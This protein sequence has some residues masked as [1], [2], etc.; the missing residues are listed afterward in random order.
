MNEFGRLFKINIFGESHGKAIGVCIDGCPVGISLSA[1]DFIPDL[2]R[3]KTGAKGTSPRIESDMPEIISGVFESKTSG[4]PITILFKNNNTKSKDYSSLVDNPRPG[5]ADFVAKSKYKGFNDYT[6]GGHFSGRLTLALVAAGVIAKKIIKSIDI[7]AS[8][9]KVGG[10]EDYEQILE[11]AIETGDSLGGLIE[12]VA[13]GIPIGLGEPFFDSVESV[14]SHLAF[15]IPAVKAIEFGLGFE[16]AAIKGSE[17][18]DIILNDKGHTETNNSGGI[19][20]GITNGNDLVFR[21]AIK[22]TSSISL[23]QNTYRYSSDSVEALEIKGR[24]DACIA[25]R[26]PVI[27]EAITAIALADLFL[28]NE[29]Y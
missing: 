27:V 9:L 24:H 6:G 12:C 18:N 13:K 3:R 10:K 11:N 22:P 2:K 8:I 20:G 21:I 14:I 19:S 17:N 4:A 23:K 26:V 1:E 29:M 25:L 16:S 28:I 5:H 15:S 7:R